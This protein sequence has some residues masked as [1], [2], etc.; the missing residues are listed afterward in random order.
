MFIHI[1]PKY[2]P[3]EPIH[4]SIKIHL[5]QITLI[6]HLLQIK[7]PIKPPNKNPPIEI[8][9]Q[10]FPCSDKNEPKYILENCKNI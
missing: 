3:K 1:R 5:D 2:E 10:N 6:K 7:P 8:P 4:T 9:H